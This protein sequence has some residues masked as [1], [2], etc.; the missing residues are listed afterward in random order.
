LRD[1]A[2]HLFDLADFIRDG[3]LLD[4]HFAL[5]ED[6]TERYGPGGATFRYKRYREGGDKDPF[7]GVYDH[8]KWL[9]LDD[10]VGVLR[11]AGFLSVDIVETRRERNGP[12]ALLIAKK[13]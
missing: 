12:R 13:A 2:Q 8:A 11:T 3:L 4:T 6:A 9:Q 10:I 7:S 5:A 1:P